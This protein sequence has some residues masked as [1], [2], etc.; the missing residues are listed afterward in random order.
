MEAFSERTGTT[1]P[2]WEALVEAESNGYMVI[3]IIRNETTTWPWAEGPFA[4]KREATNARNRL[5]TRL[6]R[7]AADRSPQA[8]FNLFIRPAWK[9]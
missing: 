9:P 8:T 5:R 4:S 7:E 6:R 1:Y 3:A 2:D